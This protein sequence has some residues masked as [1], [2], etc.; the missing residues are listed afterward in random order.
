MYSW[1][2]P[3]NAEGGFPESNLGVIVAVGAAVAMWNY[4]KGA[5]PSWYYYYSWIANRK[6]SVCKSAPW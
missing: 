2:F 3:S 6:Y 4:W 5:R 1:L